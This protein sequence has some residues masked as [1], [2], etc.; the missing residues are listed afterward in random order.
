VRLGITDASIWRLLT[1][2]DTT[3]QRLSTQVFGLEGPADQRLVLA[4]TSLTM[5]RYYDVGVNE[6][7]GRLVEQ[8]AIVIPKQRRR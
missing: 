3:L 2:P 6:D 8:I 4:D 5:R 7:M 1:A